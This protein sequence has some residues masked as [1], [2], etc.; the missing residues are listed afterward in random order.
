MRYL[1]IAIFLGI[2]GLPFVSEASPGMLALLAMIA[3]VVTFGVLEI[4]G[5][6]RYEKSN[7]VEDARTMKHGPKVILAILA[8]AGCWILFLEMNR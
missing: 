7:P 3:A 8:I 2:I 4:S 1:P 5:I 6:D